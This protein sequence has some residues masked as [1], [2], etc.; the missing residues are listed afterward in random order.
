MKYDP[1]ITLRRRIAIT[2]PTEEAAERL[3]AHGVDPDE[4][5][6]WL[7][8]AAT[9]GAGYGMV[10]WNGKAWGVHRLCWHILVEPLPLPGNVRR[11]VKVD[12]IQSDTNLVLDHLCE[13]R[14]CCN[15][16]HLDRIDQSENTK[17]GARHR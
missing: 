7:W 4:E 6:C 12:G 17:R 9:N 3:R 15:P 16:A 1:P 2:P 10:K 11:K 14:A 13:T 8:T 5:P